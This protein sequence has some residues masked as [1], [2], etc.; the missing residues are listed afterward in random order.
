MKMTSSL[1]T[2]VEVCAMVR[3][4]K[5]EPALQVA[6]DLHAGT[7]TAVV[8]AN[9]KIVVFRAVQKGG[10]GTPYIVQQAQGL[11]SIA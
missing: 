7:I 1:N 2:A 10:A 8:R 3:A 5:N 6:K 9:P 4:L 11:L